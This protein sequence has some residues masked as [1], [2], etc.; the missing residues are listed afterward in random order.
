MN[1]LSPE[2]AAQTIA[3]GTGVMFCEIVGD[4]EDRFLDKT[5]FQLGTGERPIDVAVV[6]GRLQ[7]TWPRPIRKGDSVAM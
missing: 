3:R 7:I 4:C 5:G 1:Y 6:D 2:P